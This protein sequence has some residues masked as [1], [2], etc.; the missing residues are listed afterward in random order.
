MPSDVGTSA[1]ELR[2]GSQV[3][4][5]VRK[6][7]VKLNELTSE[8]AVGRPAGTVSGELMGRTPVVKELSPGGGV[9]TMVR[10]ESDCE[11]PGLPGGVRGSME[12]R[13][14]A[15]SA[16]AVDTARW[17]SAWRFADMTAAL[18]TLGGSG[19][20]V[21]GLSA[22]WWVQR[23]LISWF[24]VP[25]EARPALR[26]VWRRSHTDMLRKDAS[27]RLVGGS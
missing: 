8:D 17:I 9:G 21:V 10:S 11:V 3:A 13:A 18:V 19:G 12:R 20:L 5:L 15:R 24:F 7:V 27:S 16:I 1:K 14:G 4:Q 2:T 22:P 23:R 26:Q 25:S 6:K